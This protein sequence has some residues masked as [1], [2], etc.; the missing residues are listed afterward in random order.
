MRHRHELNEPFLAGCGQGL[1]VPVQHRLKRLLA[2][3]VRVLRRERPDAIEDE[4]ELDVHRLLDPHGPVV[5]EGGDAVIHGHE[6]R[7][8][9]IGDA[10]D[11]RGDR[12][13]SR[14]LVPGRKR[15]G[16]GLCRDAAETDSGRSERQ[17]Q[18]RSP[19]R[20]VRRHLPLPKVRW[21]RA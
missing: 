4:G 5:V 1:H 11:K 15:I 12:L 7:P 13:F 9:L 21:V 16:L 17:L 8:A 18:N 6:V 20:T 14:P 3:P 2:L 19:V 10:R